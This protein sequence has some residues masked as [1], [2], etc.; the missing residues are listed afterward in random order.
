MDGNPEGTLRTFVQRFGYKHARN[1]VFLTTNWDKVAIGWAEMK[2]TEMKK[3]Y[4]E[5]M[6]SRGATVDRFYIKEI[7]GPTPWT[8]IGKMIQRYQ[9]TYETKIVKAGSLKSDDIV[10]V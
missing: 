10:I 2:E 8:T 3:N 6:T 7:F 4:W 1:V 9:S 5:G